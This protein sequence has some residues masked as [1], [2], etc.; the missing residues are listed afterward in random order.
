MLPTRQILREQAQAA[1]LGF[2]P[3]L[4]FGGDYARTLAQWLQRFDAAWPRI[5][6][7]GFDEN[8]R[9]RWRYYL[10]YCEA[11][12]AERAIDVGIYRFTRPAG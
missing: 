12:F 2:E 10:T 4:T 11:G 8:F 3:V 7:L 9:R 6:D 1:G 5:A